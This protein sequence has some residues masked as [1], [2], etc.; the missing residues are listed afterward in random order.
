MSKYI[1]IVS[2]WVPFPSSEYGGVQTV[3]A[4]DDTECFEITKADM[5]EYHKKYQNWESLI[6]EE[7]LAAKKYELADGNIQSGIV[8]EMIT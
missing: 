6:M 2:Y 1:Y 8:D 7:V 5:D 3:I 4:E